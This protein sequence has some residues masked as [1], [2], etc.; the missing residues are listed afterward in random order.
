MKHD[1][2]RFTRAQSETREALLLQTERSCG[3]FSFVLPI[4]FP[5][6]QLKG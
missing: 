5:N 3:P 2:D 4:S 1:P 6:P